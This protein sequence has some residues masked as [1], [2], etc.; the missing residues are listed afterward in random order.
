MDRHLK[1]F[2]LAICIVITGTPVLAFFLSFLATVLG[3]IHSIEP[4][5][6]I[7]SISGIAPLFIAVRVWYWYVKRDQAQR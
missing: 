2:G 7:A 5:Y 6:I 1:A 3:L 4:I